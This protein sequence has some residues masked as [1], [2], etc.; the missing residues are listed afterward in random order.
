MAIL[1]GTEHKPYLC[2]HFLDKLEHFK[3]SINT[4]N[5]TLK[6]PSQAQ[7]HKYYLEQL[8]QNFALRRETIELQEWEGGECTLNMISSQKGAHDISSAHD[9]IHRAHH[10]SN[11]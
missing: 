8:S 10:I 9:T 2:H 11:F 7:N 4:I 1:E 3:D 5:R 6:E